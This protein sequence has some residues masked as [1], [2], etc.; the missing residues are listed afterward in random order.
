MGRPQEIARLRARPVRVE[1]GRRRQYSSQDG[2][3]PTIA[4]V[5]RI[6]PN[7]LEVVQAQVSWRHAGLWAVYCVCQRSGDPC[8]ADREGSR[9]FERYGRGLPLVAHAVAVR[10]VLVFMGSPRPAVVGWLPFAILEVEGPQRS[11]CR[12]TTLAAASAM[13]GKRTLIH[14]RG[15]DQIPVVR[16]AGI[17]PVS[18]RCHRLIATWTGCY[19][20]C[21]AIAVSVTGRTSHDRFCARV[22]HSV[23]KRRNGR[24]Q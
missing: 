24:C 22:H 20:R 12:I 16:E 14:Y 18:A 4:A 8:A 17:W 2:R 10:L 7:S 9:C 13:G 1:S 5:S 6:S 15:V 3:A 23:P 21:R 11:I 19:R